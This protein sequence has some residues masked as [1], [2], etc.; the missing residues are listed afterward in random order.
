MG[1]S[2][3]SGRSVEALESGFRDDCSMICCWPDMLGAE[4]SHKSRINEGKMQLL[5]AGNLLECKD[6][7]APF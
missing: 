2:C 3:F 4:S 5:E 7:F 6:A 1:V